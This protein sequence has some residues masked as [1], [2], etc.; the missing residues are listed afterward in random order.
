MCT[1]A[2]AVEQASDPCLV[3]LSHCKGA[4]LSGPLRATEFYFR[5][6]R[7][8]F[9]CVKWPPNGVLPCCLVSQVQAALG[10]GENTRE[11]PEV[12]RPEL[13]CCWL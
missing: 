5:A 11:A 4:S 7:W 6:F 3:Q 1:F 2:A 10:L 9:R 12:L 13:W 8:R